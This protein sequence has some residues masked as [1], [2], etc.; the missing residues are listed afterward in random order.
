MEVRDPIHGL[1]DYSDTEEK[2]INSQIFQRLRGIKQ[3][4][5]ASLVYPGAHHTRFEHSLGVMHLAGK[6]ARCLKLSDERTKILRL[7]GLLHDIGH[8]PFS[9]VSEQIIEK[10][11]EKNILSKYKAQNV[12]EL[13]SIL[14][15][16]KSE[17]VKKILSADELDKV[18]S[19]LQKQEKRTLDKDIVSGPIDVDKFD[20]LLRDSYF[21]GVKYGTFDLDKVIESLSPVNISRNDQQ[22]GI[23]EE[24]IYSIE[25]L[26]LAKY[27]M[28]VQVYQHRLRRITDAMLVRGIEFALN[29]GLEEIEKIYKFRESD[30][31]FNN[32]IKFDDEGIFRSIIA[33]SNGWAGKF[34]ERMRGRQIF[35]EVFQVEINAENFDDSVLLNNASNP[36]E[37]QIKSINEKVAA[38]LKIPPEM[39]IVDI[40]N[41][42]N[43][44]FK[45]QQVAIDTSEIMVI[46]KL[47]KRRN[48]TAVS[49]IFSNPSIEPKKEIIYIYAPLDELD[50]REERKKFISNNRDIIF[51]QIKEELK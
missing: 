1:I 40:Q 14:F 18:K 51:N 44:T 49:T 32:F 50:T 13:L 9:H 21:A 17:E 39:V 46:N 3:L 45:Q 11:I 20:Y 37:N 12:Q 16:E 22:L 33:Q 47:G 6:V 43:P 29:E 24:G 15:I 36:S 4:A 19:L 26:L 2:I 7:A 35:K 8:G 10:N 42:S 5:L 27:H 28:N 23:R 34:F 25:Q 38:F 31:Y 41:I 48:F 30:E